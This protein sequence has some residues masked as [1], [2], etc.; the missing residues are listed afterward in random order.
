M[1]RRVLGRCLNYRALYI[2]LTLVVVVAIAANLLFE[3]GISGSMEGFYILKGTTGKPYIIK[4][5]VFIDEFDRLLVDV[6]FES[7]YH[8]FAS[9]Q[10]HN[11]EVYLE[12]EWSTLAGNGF[13]INHL[14]GGKK[15]VYCL[16]RFRDEQ[17]NKVKGP[18]IGGG[19][20]LAR[21]TEGVSTNETGV[22]YYDG[23][24]WYH[25]WCN[26]NESLWYF[27]GRQFY[28]V[29]PPKWQYVSS[30]LQSIA[31]YGI[32]I[33]SLYRVKLDGVPC[34]LE[35]YLFFKAGEPYAVV[36]NKLTNLGTTGVRCA[37]SYGDEPWIGEYGS[38]AGDVGWVKDRTVNYEEMLDLNKY[39]YAGFWD[40]GNEVIGEPHNFTG[41]AS[42]FEWIGEKPVAVYYSNTNDLPKGQKVPLNSPNSR[43]LNVEWKIKYL[44]PGQSNYYR[45][46]IGMADVNKGTK[47]PVKPQV[48]PELIK[49][50]LD[51][52]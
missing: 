17:G 47:F 5:D 3:F 32:T 7:I 23:T 49:R 43:F 36:V 35:R 46:V 1:V 27:V 50:A 9:H 10:K 37:Y 29:G 48:D 22:T 31:E 52:N 41:L 25:I 34:Q 12:S 11:D 28:L 8:A 39:S 6:N 42:F 18:L 19:L 45:F 26:T 24:K 4:D 44:W 16:G 20:P 40:Y 13:I 2:L 15:L 38:S 33:K 14:P 30:S 51:I 21:Y